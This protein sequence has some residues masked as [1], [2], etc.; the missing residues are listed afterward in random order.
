MN[1]NCGPIRPQFA[2]KR[3]LLWVVC[4]T[5]VPR[6]GHKM[7]TIGAQTATE[8]LFFKIREKGPIC[9]C[10]SLTGKELCLPLTL[11]NSVKSVKNV[12]QRTIEN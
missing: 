4:N 6:F 9:G 8:T 7:D 10:K 2:L 5:F 12:G 3:P 1:E 11:E